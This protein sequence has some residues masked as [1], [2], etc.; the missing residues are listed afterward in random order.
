MKKSCKVDFSLNLPINAV[1]FGQ[2]S[3]GVLREMYKRKLTPP[4]FPL[5][6]AADLSTQVE[7]EGFFNWLNERINTAYEKHNR[8]N[9][10]IKL[11]HFN[12]GMDS[13]SKRHLLITFYE[14]DEPTERELSVARN[15]DKLIFT[16]K[17]SQE[18]FKDKGVDSEVVPLFFDGDNFKIKNKKY[19]NADR[20]VFNLCGYLEKRKNHKSTIQAWAKKFG[21][22]K[23]YHLQCAGY[24]HFLTLE[25]NQQLNQACLDGEEFFNINFL[26]FMEKNSLYNDYL[27]SGHIVLAMSGA[28][29]WGLPEFHSVGLGKHAVVL[30]CT[31][32]KE[33]ANEKNSVLIEPSG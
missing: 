25:Q 11:W 22:N 21:N 16:N 30:N 2:V 28:E 13:F 18:V 20:I 6:G 3:V 7:D 4:V 1:S 31:G 19:F 33:W 32:Y 29:G 27:N 12:G 15:V 24:N 17:F 14:L 8:D 9:P 5:G 10:C 26:G 23:K